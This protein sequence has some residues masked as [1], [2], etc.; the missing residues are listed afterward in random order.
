MVEIINIRNT[1]NVTPK[2]AFYC[3]RGSPVGNPY[4]MKNNS[5]KE[6]NK[7]CE[8]FEIIFEQKRMTEPKFARYLGLMKQELVEGRVVK[9]A[10]WCAPLRCHCETI[11]NWLEEGNKYDRSKI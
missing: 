4:V 3:G 2:D 8:Y 5:L 7:A 10:C 11:K 9:L 1:N 6:R